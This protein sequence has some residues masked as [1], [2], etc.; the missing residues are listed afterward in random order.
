M[1][2]NLGGIL[3][4]ILGPQIVT[5]PFKDP[6]AS[7]ISIAKEIYLNM[8]VYFVL[9]LVLFLIFWLHFPDNENYEEQPDLN[10]SVKSECIKVLS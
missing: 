1:M 3:P 10:H 7:Q 8:L 5:D 6:N 2:A 9:S 4:S